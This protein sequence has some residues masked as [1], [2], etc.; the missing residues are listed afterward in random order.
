MVLLTQRQGLQVLHLNRSPK[1][2][3]V[4][5]QGVQVKPVEDVAKL[6]SVGASVNLLHEM[7]GI[8]V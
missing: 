7:C 8:C 5:G 6:K 3:Q 4:D 1:E 2:T